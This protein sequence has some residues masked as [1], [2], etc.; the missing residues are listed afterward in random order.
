MYKFLYYFLNSNFFVISFIFFNQISIYKFYFF[1][2]SKIYINIIIIW[3]IIKLI[4]L[5]KYFKI[6]IK[7]LL[8]D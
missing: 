4:K 8:L 6:N 5:K 3:S 7:K 1:N 2:I